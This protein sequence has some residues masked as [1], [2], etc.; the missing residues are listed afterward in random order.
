MHKV[1]S[2]DQYCVKSF[3]YNYFSISGQSPPVLSSSYQ[4][5]SSVS[6]V[7][8][9]QQSLSSPGAVHLWSEKTGK[10]Y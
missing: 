3:I 4:S 1:V 7:T 8:R 9:R 5:P 10:M 6:S 2:I